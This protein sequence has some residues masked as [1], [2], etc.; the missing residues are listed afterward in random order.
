MKVRHLTASISAAF[1]I[2]ALSAFPGSAQALGLG[3]FS[4]KSGLGQP[5]HA[6]VEVFVS[7]K[8]EAESVTVRP[9]QPSEYSR[10]GI[11]YPSAL[12]TLTVTLSKR[13]DQIFAVLK[14]DA[15]VDE[16]NFQVMLDGEAGMG[17]IRRTYAALLRPGMG[18]TTP[19]PA[20]IERPQTTPAKSA[21]V[22]TAQPASQPA[23][24]P[25][26]AGTPAAQNTLMYSNIDQ[27]GAPETSAPRIKAS[28]RNQPVVQALFAVVPKGWKGYAEDAG[29]K[30]TGTTSWSGDGRTWPEVMDEILYTSQLFATLDWAKKEISFRSMQAPAKPGSLTLPAVS[31]ANLKAAASNDP[32]RLSAEYEARLQA[33][34]EELTRAE[35]AR[36]KAEEDRARAEADFRRAQEDAAA[37]REQARAAIEQAELARAQAEEARQQIAQTRD[38]VAIERTEA[39]SARRQA[40]ENAKRSFAEAESARREAELA[41]SAHAEAMAAAQQQAERAKMLEEENRRV[42]RLEQTKLPSPPQ[43]ST[44]SGSGQPLVTSAGFNVNVLHAIQQIV[45]NGWMVYSND[46]GVGKVPPVT[47]RGR[48]REWTVVLDEVLS[49][50]GL[51]GTTDFGRREVRISTAPSSGASPRQ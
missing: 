1:G 34:R 26:S 40:V 32:A 5:L 3:Q 50:N 41:R 23:K 43:V 17:R 8:R 18:V 48:N 36:T 37:A 38:Q 9:A 16:P 21:P 51:V 29:V 22:A 30:Q 28:G 42:A 13:G 4:L 39:D 20:G 10:Q 7:D 24:V 14:T 25:A 12:S 6:E 49:A 45:P 44:P 33:Q 27:I 15:A 2:A 11:A 31:T 47:W 35:Q 46:V 19:I